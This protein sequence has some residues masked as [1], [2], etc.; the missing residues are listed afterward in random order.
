VA[1]GSHRHEDGARPGAPA[2]HSAKQDETV[3]SYPEEAPVG[4]CDS[5]EASFGVVAPC[6]RR[7]AVAESSRTTTGAGPTTPVTGL[8]PTTSACAGLDRWFTRQICSHITLGRTV[9]GVTILFAARTPSAGRTGH[10][11][12]RA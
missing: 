1:T 4:T 5:E 7:S 10:A 11:V 6:R 2:G 3:V 9:R 12:H 8:R